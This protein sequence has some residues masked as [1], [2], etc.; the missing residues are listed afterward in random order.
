MLGA[1]RAGIS[2]SRCHARS[3]AS[4]PIRAAKAA[5]WPGGALKLKCRLPSPR[6]PKLTG[7]APGN[8][9]ST[10]AVASVDE[11]RDGSHRHG[12][13]VLDRGAFA[14]LRLPKCFRACARSCA[15]GPGSAPPLRR[16]TRSCAIGLRQRRL[17][18]APPGWRP[19]R[20]TLPSAHTRA[21]ARQA[22]RGCREYASAPVPGSRRGISSKAD[23]RPP[24][25]RLHMAQQAQRRRG[26]GHRGEGGHR[27]R[28]G[29]GNRRRLAAVTTPSVPSA[30]MKICLRS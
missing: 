23:S 20:R 21:K 12:D 5:S 18:S 29:C 2:P 11:G 15:P 28:P 6:W 19:R 30:P 14:L 4:R 25:L 24:V 7:R 27:S 22:D 26:R 10:A 9:F 13:V 16:V 1:D 17:R 8:F 3:A